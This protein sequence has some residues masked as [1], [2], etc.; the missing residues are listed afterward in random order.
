MNSGDVPIFT[1]RR[2]LGAFYTP[3]ELSDILA[4]WAIQQPTDTVFEPGFGGCH[5]V[6]SS[7]SKLEA[8]GSMEPNRQI[9][10]CDI[11][12]HAF[13]CLSKSLGHEAADSPNFKKA[14]F[15]SVSPLHFC[16]D[17]FDIVI[18]NPPYISNQKLP[19]EQ[20]RLGRTTV[21]KWSDQKVGRANLWLYFVYHSLSFLNQDGRMA[22][23]LPGS[24]LGADYAK[25]L[26]S[27]IPRNFS[28]SLAVAV[29]SRQFLNFGAKE[30]SILLLADGFGSSSGK[31]NI[32]YCEA[33]SLSEIKSIKEEWEQEKLVIANLEPGFNNGSFGSIGST[34]MKRY[35]EL[36]STTNA[37]AFGE[38]CTIKIGLVTGDS[39]YLV[40]NAKNIDTIGLNPDEHFK[41][42]FPRV[43]DAA[44]LEYDTSDYVSSVD[45]NRKCYLLDIEPKHFCNS[46]VFSYVNDYPEEK[47][48]ANKTFNNKAKWYNTDDG[49]QPDAFLS[50]MTSGEPRLILNSS[51]INCTNS[52]HRI[53]FGLLYQSITQQR[54]ISISMQTSYSQLSAEIECRTTGTGML[55][56]EPSDAKRIRILLP[57]ALPHANIRQ[58]FYEIDFLVRKNKI[59]EARRSADEFIFD[60]CAMED[61]VDQSALFEE[62]LTLTRVKRK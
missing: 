5:F 38:L 8:R 55:K 62:A 32:E 53:Y 19:K 21:E 16:E 27:M 56:I 9:F 18:G 42:I 20:D 49:N 54:L 6:E 13:E 23:V 34:T 30:K 28:R 10:G 26:R 35:K 29:K 51:K 4:E 25:S 22:W 24:F 46:R 1:R 47:K 43:S 12:D 31:I 40:M 11:D 59:L 60:A 48:A 45:S 37:K 15:L 50:Y 57:T 33:G 3:V 17:G 39:R 14:D 58:K 44:G 36:S 2:E 41:P 52:V 61:F 7:K